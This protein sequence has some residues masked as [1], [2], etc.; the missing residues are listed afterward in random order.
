MLGEKCRTLNPVFSSFKA[1]TRLWLNASDEATSDSSQL[2]INLEIAPLQTVQERAFIC[3][4]HK[5]TRSSSR[6]KE[7][8]EL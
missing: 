5:K 4:F 6:R 8:H 7:V 1:S 2:T 3:R